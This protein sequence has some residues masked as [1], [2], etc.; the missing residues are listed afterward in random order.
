MAK[1]LVS[2]LNVRGKR[3]LVRLD[4]NVPVNDRG[5]ITDDQ[6]IVRA[7]PTYPEVISPCRVRNSSVSAKR[8]GIPC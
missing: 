7:L 8:R 1:R 2:D 5:E 6:R 4:L 3:V